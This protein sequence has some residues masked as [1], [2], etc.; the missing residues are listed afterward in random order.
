M[1]P[2]QGALPRIQHDAAQ[3]S[4]D[5]HSHSP[6]EVQQRKLGSSHQA[7]MG[8]VRDREFGCTRA[9]LRSLSSG[10]YAILWPVV[11]S[12][13]PLTNQR[14]RTTTSHKVIL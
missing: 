9:R 2:R 14:I 5:S 8:S 6:E 13:R 10:I 3:E 12:A 4:H 11:A 1:Y 7:A